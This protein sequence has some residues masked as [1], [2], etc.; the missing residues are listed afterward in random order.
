MNKTRLDKIK[1]KQNKIR[2]DDL[3]LQGGRKANVAL[4]SCR[5]TV[6]I[7]WSLFTKTIHCIY[8]AV[9]IGPI[10]GK[11][12]RHYQW[13]SKNH[14]HG[15]PAGLFLVNLTSL[16]HI[17]ER[18]TIFVGCVRNKLSDYLAVE[19]LMLCQNRQL[20]V[21]SLPKSFTQY[22]Q[23]KYYSQASGEL[24]AIVI[25][26]LQVLLY[27]QLSK[28][29]LIVEIQSKI[30]KPYSSPDRSRVRQLHRIWV[31]LQYE[32]QYC[33]TLLQ[34]CCWAFVETLWQYCSLGLQSESSENRMRKLEN[35]LGTQ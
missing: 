12:M 28:Q 25:K 15:D 20:L 17:R 18:H 6:G 7:V 23:R 4:P 2:V 35:Q 29:F 1:L 19:K 16:D 13:S 33:A 10:S 14:N 24:R 30:R 27:L 26:A 9:Y 11:I 21:G 31:T 34:K 3:G 8:S 22:I 32:S 5:K